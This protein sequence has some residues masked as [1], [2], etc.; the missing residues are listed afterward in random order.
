MDGAFP[1]Y[2]TST[3]FLKE[4]G[5][6]GNQLYHYDSNAMKYSSSS[7][8]SSTTSSRQSYS[9]PTST[10]PQRVPR[11]PVSNN[12]A[13]KSSPHNN[14]W[15][16]SSPKPPP[17]PQRTALHSPH[18]KYHAADTVHPNRMRTY[19][20]VTPLNK[21][22]KSIPSPPVNHNSESYVRTRRHSQGS[23]LVNNPNK[24][25]VVESKTTFWYPRSTD[26]KE[27]ESLEPLKRGLSKKIRGLLQ[28]HRT[29]IEQGASNEQ[30]VRDCQESLKRSRTPIMNHEQNPFR[31][32]SHTENESERNGP[33]LQFS[34]SDF[35]QVDNYASTV[36]Q[37][38]P[39]LTPSLLSQKFLV[40]P[41]RRELFRL[42]ALFIWL[43]QNIRPDYHQKR[44]N[45]ML[46]QNSL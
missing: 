6:H 19:S 25:Q 3:P 37:R 8:S 18:N 36:Q 22:I 27:F 26:N 31:V 46:L 16:T 14:E 5:Y 17:T 20:Q 4:L 33:P 32:L 1:R 43:I 45:I 15:K 29:Q 23:S 9:P 7:S 42:R 41:Y 28:P 12:P 44:D 10:T 21:P 38:G 35:I 11:K 2:S 34:E 13:L 39:L 24:K 40:R 30:H